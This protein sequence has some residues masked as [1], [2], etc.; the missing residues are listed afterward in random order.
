MSVSLEG[1]S[2]GVEEVGEVPV[3]PVVE[4]AVIISCGGVNC[5]SSVSPPVFGVEMEALCCSIVLGVETA[6]GMEGLS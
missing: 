3:E 5:S 1:D 2:D 6:L 4:F